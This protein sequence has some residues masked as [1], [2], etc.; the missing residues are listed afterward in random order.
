MRLYSVEYIQHGNP[1]GTIPNRD[2]A[3]DMGM[4]L[5]FF[6]SDKMHLKSAHSSYKIHLVERHN[7]EGASMKSFTSYIA[8]LSVGLFTLPAANAQS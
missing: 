4:A 7:Q 6:P 5:D 2:S 8:A 1:P 3:H